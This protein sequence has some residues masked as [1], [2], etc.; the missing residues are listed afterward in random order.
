[1][2]YG[3]KKKLF[4]LKKLFTNALN[5]KNCLILENVFI[6]ESLSECKIIY[7]FNGFKVVLNQF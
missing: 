1:M 3:Y 5:Y 7:F 6:T 2:N 4:S